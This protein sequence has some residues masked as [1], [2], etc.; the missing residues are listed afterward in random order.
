MRGFQLWINLAGQGK[1]EGRRLPRHPGR[2]DSGG[3]TRPAVAES[4]SSPGRWTATAGARPARSGT[5]DRSAVLRRR[6]AGRRE[7]HAIVLPAGL[8]RLRL[9]VR[10]SA[11]QSARRVRRNVLA[12]TPCAGVLS[13][14]DECRADSGGPDGGS[15][16]LLAGRPL[17]EPIVQYGPFVMNTREE[18]EQAVRDYARRRADRRERPPAPQTNPGGVQCV[19]VVKTRR[20]VAGQFLRYAKRQPFGWR[21]PIALSIRGVALRLCCAPPRIG[22]MPHGSFFS[23]GDTVASR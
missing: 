16:I 13:D 22:A 20:K 21:W 5:V 12:D 11:S 19:F 1:D 15:V 18:I 4:R 9:P 14:G 10:G 2:R 3:R 7:I 8:S 23:S 17:L 6:A